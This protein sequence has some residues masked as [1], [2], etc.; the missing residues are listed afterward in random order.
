MWWG[1]KTLRSVGARGWSLMMG[2]DL[3][4]LSW[5][6]KVKIRRLM[7]FRQ[8]IIEVSERSVLIDSRNMLRRVRGKSQLRLIEIWVIKSKWL[9]IPLLFMIQIQSQR[10]IHLSKCNILISLKKL[11]MIEKNLLWRSYKNRQ[12]VKNHWKKQKTK[13]QVLNEFWSKKMTRRLK[14]KMIKRLKKE[15]NTSKIK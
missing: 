5:G 8:R 6:M 2:F 13:C 10:M 11:M 14:K 7:G 12:W 4:M 9:M 3:K 1:L 15:T